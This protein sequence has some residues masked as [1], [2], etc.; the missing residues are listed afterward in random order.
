[1]TFAR[2][3]SL[4]I[5]LLAP[6]PA[7]ADDAQMKEAEAAVRSFVDAVAKG[8]PAA[9]A[10]VL[11]PEFQIVR[12]NGVGY[13]REDYLA[14]GLSTVRVE[15]TPAIKDLTVTQQGDVMVAR[16]SLAT[17]MTVSGKAVAAQAPR[18]SVFRKDGERWLIVA[19]ANF[20]AIED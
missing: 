6:L 5:L 12:S 8:D 19:H 9:L 10:A 20:A 13:G 16:Y 4:F 7:A 14:Q 18:L 3:C 2:L 11:A 15:G 1:M 17:S